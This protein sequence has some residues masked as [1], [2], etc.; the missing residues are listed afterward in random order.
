MLSLEIMQNGKEVPMN[1]NK[2]QCR[3]IHHVPD[4]GMRYMV[5]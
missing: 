3:P 1:T 2:V 5:L 4:S